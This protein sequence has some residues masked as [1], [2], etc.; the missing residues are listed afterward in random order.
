[1]AFDKHVRPVVQPSPLYG[2]VVNVETQRRDKVQRR[3]QVVRN[4]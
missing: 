1:V 2:L 3:L 4:C